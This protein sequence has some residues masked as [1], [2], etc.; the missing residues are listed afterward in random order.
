MAGTLVTGANGF[1]GSHLVEALLNRGDQVTGFVRS[2]ARGAQ[3]E[4]HGAR[5]A[6]GDVTDL[7]SV[8]RAVAGKSVVFHLAGL[9]KALGARRFFEVNQ[10]G[11][12]NVARACAEEDSPP[13]LVVVSSLAAAGPVTTGRLREE[14][15]EPRPVSWYGRSKRAGE[16]AAARFADRVP[17]TIVRPPIVFGEA[18]RLSLEVFKTIAR[19]GVH[20]VP[21]YVPRKYSMIHADDLVKALLLAAERG[22]RLPAGKSDPSGTGAGFYFAACDEHPSWY[23]FGRMIGKALGRRLT[24]TIPFA[25]PVVRAVGA[26]GELAGRFR[27]EQA[28]MNLDKA[29]E[30]TAGSWI[31]SAGKAQRELGFSISV[32][33]FDRLRQTAQWYQAAGWL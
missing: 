24:L 30:A 9:T 19:S 12:R 1:I 33:L 3:L 18:D 11:V 10:R 32:P 31:C 15:D 20:L 2:S 27:G 13:V 16:K 22:S 25:M 7:A 6:Q 28:V 4:E 29:R 14:V 8:R 26:F 17:I 23:Q 21:G 5:L